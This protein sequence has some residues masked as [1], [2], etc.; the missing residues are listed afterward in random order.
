[1]RPGGSIKAV[2]LFALATVLAETVGLPLVHPLFHSDAL[3][4]CATASLDDCQSGTAAEQTGAAL[5]DDSGSHRGVERRYPC[6]ICQYT[7]THPRLPVPA[8]AA[9]GESGGPV[10]ARAPYR[11]VRPVRPALPS[12]GPRAPPGEVPC[13]SL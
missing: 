1:M 3:P 11:S 4:C 6:P 5:A 12:C 2:R 9:L 13:H 10:L 7:Q 8:A